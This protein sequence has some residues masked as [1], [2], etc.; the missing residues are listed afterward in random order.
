VHETRHSTT[1]P[2]D[3]DDIRPYNGMLGAVICGGLAA[4]LIGVIATMAITEATTGT[5]SLTPL[6]A[7]LVGGLVNAL[8]L[9]A[10]IVLST[11]AAQGGLFRQ[12][13]R[14][15][16][17]LDA[18]EA[19]QHHRQEQHE[20]MIAGLVDEFSARFEAHE[21]RV[22]NLIGEV[23]AQGAVDAIVERRLRSV[24]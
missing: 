15:I 18:I 6:T 9:I 4:I 2:P 8:I 11:K 22:S 3:P 12:T 20:R 5:L 10:F 14:V 19:E 1:T 23:Y 17:R 16:A 21:Q 7:V 24:N 13:D